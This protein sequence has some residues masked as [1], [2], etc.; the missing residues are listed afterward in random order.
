MQHENSETT[1]DSLATTPRTQRLGYRITK[2]TFDIV[3]SGAVIII[4]FI[5]SLVL[6]CFIAKD[7]GGSPIYAQERVGKD[8]K[9]FRIYKFRTMVADADN[10]E[11]HLSPDQLE[12]WKR[13]RKVENDPRITKLGSFLR[14]TS[15]DE[16]PQFLNVIAGQMSVVGPRPITKDELKHFGDD[17]A[18]L[19]SRRP[20]ITGWW[21]T[22][23]RN[24][25]SFDTGERQ[26]LELYYID[27]ATLGLDVRIVLM[28][29]KTMIDGTGA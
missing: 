16:I 13:E 7:T 11:K 5:P 26:A 28:T 17:Q 27:N 21:Q 8:N 18:K 1:E 20:G 24:D 9:S 6:S 15:I 14:R 3:F 29:L 23:S 25:A 2:R 4:G 10:V 19:L 22:Q 12:E